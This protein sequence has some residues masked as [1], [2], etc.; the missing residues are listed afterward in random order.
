MV[1]GA[2]VGAVLGLGVAVAVVGTLVLG[3]AEVGELVG[4]LVG[5]LV[6]AGARIRND[7][8]TYSKNIKK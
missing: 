1:G 6:V 4:A 3:D 5:G 7:P 2:V 8:C